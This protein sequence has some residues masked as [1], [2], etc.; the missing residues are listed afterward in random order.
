MPSEARDPFSIEPTEHRFEQLANEDG[1]RF[2]WA[3]DL[4]RLLG[5]GDLAALEG[6]VVKAMEVCIGLEVDIA[7][8]VQAVR[9]QLE[10]RSQED[11][12]LSRF[13]CYLVAMNGDVRKPQVAQAQAYFAAF[14]EACRLALAESDGVNRLTLRGDVTEGEKSLSRAAKR[15]GVR[16]YGLF[17]NAGYRGLYNM[18]LSRL[19]SLKKTPR[20]R[21]PLD[22]MGKTELAANL[23]RITQ[24]EERIKNTGIRGQLECERAAHT[25]G[26][27]VRRAM[28]EMGGTAPE[29]L[30][31]A[32][33]I[34]R[35]RTQIKST[36]REFKKVDEA[37]SA[38]TAATDD[39]S[40]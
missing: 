36:Q 13:A 35:V 17:Q 7:D 21:S 28:L 5:Y 27:K 2:W 22:F 18:D 38:T 33:D 40:E 19:K 30:P 26:Q 20:Q 10:G 34:K 23:F 39:P 4:A 11:F 29:V 1:F 25:V 16:E 12:K 6:A 37:A 3:S 24:T 32:R 8:N 14:A 15:A 31:P 9:R